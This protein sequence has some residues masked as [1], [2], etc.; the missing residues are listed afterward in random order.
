MIIRQC[1]FSLRLP[2][3]SSAMKG[4]QNRGGMD[5]HVLRA[6]ETASHVR[7]AFGFSTSEMGVVNMPDMCSK[8]CNDFEVVNGLSCRSDEGRR[9]LR[10]G[11]H[12]Y[13][14]V[15]VNVHALYGCRL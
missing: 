10:R 9:Q 6:A 8:A 12:V 13:I 4:G 14:H 11:N 2:I 15:Y 5:G 1:V 3:L 7:T